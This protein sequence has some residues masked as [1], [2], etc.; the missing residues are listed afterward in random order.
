MPSSDSHL[1]PVRELVALAQS[2]PGG[3]LPDET[4][5]SLPIPLP[6]T[7][8]GSGVA[9]LFLP[10]RLRF[11]TGLILVAPSRRAVLDAVS[12][13]VRSFE[14]V[15]PADLGV[16]DEPGEEL[17]R[18]GLPEGVTR[19]AYLEAQASLYDAYDRLLGP[20]FA[21]EA[22][23]E[24]GRAARKAASEMKG[25]FAV[26]GEPPLAPYYAAVGKAFF[27]WVNE[28]AILP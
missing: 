7:T 13:N 27:G 8:R 23:P 15:R 21:G 11:G 3:R 24:T 2:G 26:V 22:P 17:G 28:L 20:W 4:H 10:S 25:A 18:F 19:E 5:Q 6:G 1:K 9:F 16:A 14:P 12:G